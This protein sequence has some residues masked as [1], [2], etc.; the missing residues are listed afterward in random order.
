MGLEVRGT[1]QTGSKRLALISIHLLPPLHIRM[2]TTIRGHCLLGAEY[3][4]IVEAV[5]VEQS[6]D[7]NK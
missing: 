6:A 4:S 3:L 2:H 5:V 7:D 1:K